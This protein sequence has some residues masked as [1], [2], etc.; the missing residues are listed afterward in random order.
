MRAGPGN[1]TSGSS[2]GPGTAGGTVSSCSSPSFSATDQTSAL[3]TGLPSWVMATVDELA[4][5]PARGV[6]TSMSIGSGRATPR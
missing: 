5:R 2:S 3:S 4:V 6:R 1:S